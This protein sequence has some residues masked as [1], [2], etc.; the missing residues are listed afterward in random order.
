[1]KELEGELYEVGLEGL[2][3]LHT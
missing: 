3:K 2:K 1:V